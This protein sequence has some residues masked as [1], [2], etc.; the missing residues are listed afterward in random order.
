M[1]YCTSGFDFGKVWVAVPVPSLTVEK[2]PD[3]LLH[4]ETLQ[5]YAYCSGSKARLKSSE[6]KVLR[7]DALLGN[8]VTSGEYNHKNLYDHFCSLSEFYLYT[9]ASEI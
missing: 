1:N 5:Q 4:C 8:L 3:I 2:V 7:F 9:S 6:T